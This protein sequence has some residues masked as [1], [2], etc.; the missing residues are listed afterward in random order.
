MIQQGF[1]SI[2]LA[3]AASAPPRRIRTY[4]NLKVIYFW[5]ARRIPQAVAASAPPLRIRTYKYLKVFYF[6]PARR[7]ENNTSDTDESRPLLRWPGVIA[8][9]DPVPVLLLQWVVVYKNTRV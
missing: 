3:L 6:W 1:N 5:P 7:L 9:I 8:R 2:P 4:K